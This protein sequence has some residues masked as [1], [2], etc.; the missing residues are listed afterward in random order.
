VATCHDGAVAFARDFARARWELQLG[1]EIPPLIAGEAL[2]RVTGNPTKEE[3]VRLGGLT[4]SDNAG[5]TT[6]RACAQFRGPNEF[7]SLLE[8]YRKAYWKPG[9]LAQPNLQAATLRTL[10]WLMQD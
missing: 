5:S 3:A 7:P 1:D 10:L 4:L 6:R 8:D 2:F 9:L